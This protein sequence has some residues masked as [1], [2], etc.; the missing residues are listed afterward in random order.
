[1]HIDTVVGVGAE[2]GAGSYLPAT[3]QLRP[4]ATRYGAYITQASA[5]DEESG[6]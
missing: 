5:V 4:R 1:M 3:F 6:A 2:L